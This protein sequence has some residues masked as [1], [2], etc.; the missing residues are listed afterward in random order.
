MKSGLAR[1]RCAETHSTRKSDQPALLYRRLNILQALTRQGHK[2]TRTVAALDIDPLRLPTGALIDWYLV[3]KRIDDLPQR[4]K[5]LAEAQQELRNR[6]SYAGSRLV[7]TTER[8]DYWWWMMLNADANAFRLIEAMLDNPDWKDDLPRL[9]QGAM[10]RQVRGRWLTTTANAWAR[11]TLDRFARAFER[12]P[13]DGKT[14]V[15]LAKAS[16]EID[17]SQAT[18]EM[19]PPIA[20]PWPTPLGK[21]DALS[22]VHQG[23]GKPWATIQVL[24]AIPDGPSRAMGYRISRQVTPIQEKVPGK[25]SR[26]D[27]WRIKLDITAN[28]DMTWVV[29]SDP[30]PGG[31][32]ILGSGLG[33]DSAIATAGESGSSRGWLAYIERGFEAWRAYYEY[34]P[35]GKTSIEYTVRLN[36][37]GT[38]NLPPTRVEALYAPEVFGAA[39]N[40]AVQV[41]A[42]P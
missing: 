24:A 38:F 32:I 25:V 41:H 11:V 13:V 8:E 40:T 14:L 35:Q 2:P 27:V 15:T 30:V 16:G 9:V 1:L 28:S 3:V 26:G 23:N 31:A 6:L 4:E 42:R 7:F 29:I 19:R 22:L 20:L 37:V 18:G 17:W 36:N 33:R 12:D 10:E 21:D 5:K 34:L 39:P